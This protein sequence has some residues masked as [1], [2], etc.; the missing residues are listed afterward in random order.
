MQ[1]FIKLHSL[2]GMYVISHTVAIRQDCS[3]F[4][5]QL[6]GLPDKIAEMS[7]K[8]QHTK[9]TLTKSISEAIA[10]VDYL[11][12]RCNGLENQAEEKFT[13]ILSKPDKLSCTQV[14]QVST[15]YHSECICDPSSY[16][17]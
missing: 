2:E 12:A 5:S 13:L 17:Y 14:Q 11:G 9:V 1:R 10:A 15:F 7:S 6:A 8:L 16:L 3:D 4:S